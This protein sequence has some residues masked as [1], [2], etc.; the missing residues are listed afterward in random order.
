MPDDN[1]GCN[2]QTSSPWA[3]LACGDLEHHRAQSADL[4]SDSCEKCPVC[5]AGTPN[6]G[7]RNRL[8][9]TRVQLSRLWGSEI[10]SSR[11]CGSSTQCLC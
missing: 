4:D 1:N 11:D 2:D 3:I 5:S 8:R 9:E 6:T 10:L 7:L